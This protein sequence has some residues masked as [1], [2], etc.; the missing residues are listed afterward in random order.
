MRIHFD[1]DVR[2]RSIGK[3]L[4]KKLEARGYEIQLTRAQHV[5]PACLDIQA[6]PICS[7]ILEN[8]SP[9]RLTHSS[10]PRS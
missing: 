10:T 1:T 6:G 4:K 2:P 3:A 9:L 7:K 5:S 8:K